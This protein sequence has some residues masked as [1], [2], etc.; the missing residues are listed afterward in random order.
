MH[1]L[2]IVIQSWLLL[3]IAFQGGSKIAGA[4]QQVELFESIRLPQWFRV[5]TGIVQLI[6][7][8]AL[9]VGYWYP[10]TAAWAGVW[11]GVTMA[12][13]ILSHIRVKHPVGKTAPA[14]V[15]LALAVAVLLLFAGDLPNPLA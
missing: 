6:G 2:S 3:W 15:T 9:V 8:A 5:V 7:A 13:A 12:I 14:I 11:L 1:I 4:K 10:G